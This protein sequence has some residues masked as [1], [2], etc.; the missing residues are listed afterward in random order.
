MRL[1]KKNISRVTLNDLLRR[2]RTTLSKFIKD[3]GIVTYDLLVNRCNSMG[4]VSPT[5]EEFNTITGNDKLYSVSS[6]TEGV[7]VLD[8]PAIISDYSG[9]IIPDVTD[10]VKIDIVESTS[11]DQTDLLAVDDSQETTT[12]YKKKKKKIS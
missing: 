6:P 2:K 3:N 5:E 10:V 12:D 4:V 11:N 1:L 7:V 9:K 8:P